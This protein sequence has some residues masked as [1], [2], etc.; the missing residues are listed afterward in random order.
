MDG[1]VI[2]GSN[3]SLPSLPN[4]Q[5]STAVSTTSRNQ[6]WGFRGERRRLQSATVGLVNDEGDRV[7]EETLLRR[8]DMDANAFKPIVL[9]GVELR[10]T[11]YE[12]CDEGHT[13]LLCTTC[14]NGFT[15]TGNFR[16]Q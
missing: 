3:T 8:I 2:E 4:E 6:N 12:Q 5:Q 14:D 15:R 1:L 16:C 9:P 11:D 7:D 13:G 10:A